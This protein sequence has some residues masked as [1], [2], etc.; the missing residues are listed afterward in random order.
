MIATE[1]EFWQ[2]KV[3]AEQVRIIYQQLYTIMFGWVAASLLIVALFWSQVSEV[4]LLAWSGAIIVQSFALLLPLKLAFKRVNPPDK[5]MKKWGGMVTLALGVYTATGG[6]MGALFYLPEAIEYQMLLGLFV[7]GSSAVLMISTSSYLPAYHITCAA[8]LVPLFVRYLFHGD[9]LHWELAI[10]MAVYWITLTAGCH[11]I[12]QSIVKSLGLGYRNQAL[13]EEVTKQKEVAE[14]A[15]LAKSRFLAAASHDLR[16]PLQAQTLFVAELYTRLH[17]PEKCRVIL[18][19]LD[20]SIHAMRGLFNALLDISKLDAGV[21]KPRVKDFK[22]SSLLAVIEDEYA[23]H[24]REKGLALKIRC[25]SSRGGQNLVVRTDPRLLDCV[26]RNLIVNAIRYTQS[27]KV[28]VGCRFRGQYL[29]VEIWD[30]GPGIAEKYQRE[31]FQE[32][33]QIENQQ[34]DR[35][36]GLGLGLSVV[37]RITKLLGCSLRLDSVE[38]KGS[39]FTVMVPLSTSDP[40]TV[41]NHVKFQTGK[42]ILG[43]ARVVVI[44]DDI[45]IQQAMQ[46]LL[47]SWGCQVLCADSGKKML[48]MLAQQHFIPDIILVDYR[49]PGAMTGVQAVENIR[50]Q[51]NNN[52]PAILITGDTGIDKLQ[53]VQQSAIPLMHKPVQP[54]KLRTL[55]QY[56]LNNIGEA[57]G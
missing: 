36:Q 28:L 24:V 17:E 43:G 57:M 25:R 1:N 41:R 50:V 13:V 22:I 11:R 15:N 29:A 16:Q 46:G 32:F 56:L 37:R 54:G 48:S 26:L 10:A 35:S 8:I 33:Y 6:A 31:I 30:T 23:G 44:E 45:A 4:L 7:V 21:V 14:H 18:S 51:L 38:G 9:I 42:H 2:Q 49:L 34:R 27:G 19:R 52:V 47:E 39:R 40:E 53:D 20:E 55:M 12:N 3:L 5:E